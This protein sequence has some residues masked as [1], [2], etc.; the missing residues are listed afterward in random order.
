MPNITTL[1]PMYMNCAQH[2]IIFYWFCW[3]FDGWMDLGYISS[4]GISIV[5]LFLF[6]YWFCPWVFIYLFIYLCCTHSTLGVVLACPGYIYLLGQGVAIWGKLDSGGFGRKYIY[7]VIEEDLIRRAA[8]VVVRIIAFTWYLKSKKTGFGVYLP[9]GWG[10]WGRF[11]G[12]SG[13][14]WNISKKRSN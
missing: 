7:R 11:L 5:L 13:I 14:F 6:F 4:M 12:G 8:D 10:P 2:R 9:V 1:H 3:S